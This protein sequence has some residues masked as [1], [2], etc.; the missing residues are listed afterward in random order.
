ME[1]EN[2]NMDQSCPQASLSCYVKDCEFITDDPLKLARHARLHPFV[3]KHQCQFVGC[4]YSTN[5]L[6]RLTAHVRTHTGEKP[7]VCKHE[8]CT[9]SAAQIGKKLGKVEKKVFFSFL[10]PCK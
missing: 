3:K 6:T 5:D 10:S 8:G 7:Y 1:V 2:I 9:Y 4:D